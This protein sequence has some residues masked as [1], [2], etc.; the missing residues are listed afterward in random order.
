[1][2]QSKT[3]AALSL[4]ALAPTFFTSLQA[5]AG[6]VQAQLRY[7]KRAAPDLTLDTVY[8]TDASQVASRSYDYVIVR[9]LQK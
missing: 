3:S 5:H 8:T 9:C 7:T 6:D 1:M 4:I 2:L